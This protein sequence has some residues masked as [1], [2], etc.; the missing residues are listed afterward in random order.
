MRKTM[1]VPK[2]PQPIFLAPYP[3]TS[4]RSSLLTRSVLSEALDAG[5]LRRMTSCGAPVARASPATPHAGPAQTQ[6][7]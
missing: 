3:A 7:S 2:Q 4:P 5:T 6:V 1:M